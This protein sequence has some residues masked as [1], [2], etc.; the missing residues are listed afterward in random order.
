MVGGS[1][2][3]ARTGVT[4]HFEGARAF[5]NV[6]RQVELGPRSA[7]T[8]AHDEAR[9]QIVAAL[10]ALGLHPTVESFVARTPVG[11]VPMANVLAT[12]PAT[13][14]AR[15]DG[16]VMVAAHYDTKLFKQFNFVGANDGG[17]GTGALLELG[18]SL[19]KAPHRGMPVV[20]AFL[21]G[22]EAFGEWSHTDSLYGSRHLAFQMLQDGR[23]RRIKA[24]ILMDMIGDADLSIVRD[25]YSTPWLRDLVWKQAAAL[26]LQRYFSSDLMGVEDDH[27]PFVARGI[28]SVVLIDFSFGPRGTNGYWHTAQDTLDKVTADSLGHVGRVVESTVLRLLDGAR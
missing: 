12:V 25:A 17:S 16:C 24:F 1:W 14:G 10:E 11:P 27:L 3:V 15:G 9:R 18:R 21:D 7:G 13:E 19:L 26:G 8:P 4:L 6:R 2:V 23:L 28:P 5:E 20:L 22:E